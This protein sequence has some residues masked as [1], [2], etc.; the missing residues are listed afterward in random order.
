MLNLRAQHY[1]LT[2]IFTLNRDMFVG[3]TYTSYRYTPRGDCALVYR[4]VWDFIK[5]SGFILSQ[6]IQQ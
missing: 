6:C 4:F 5:L 3:G 2:K 1:L